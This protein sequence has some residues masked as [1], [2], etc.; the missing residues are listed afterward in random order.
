MNPQS[1]S[2]VTY[3]T[4]SEFMFD[5]LSSRVPFL[6]VGGWGTKWRGFMEKIEFVR[7]YAEKQKEDHIIIFVDGFDTRVIKDPVLAVERFKTEFSSCRALFSYGVV[8]S[9]TF[10]ACRRR[11]FGVKRGPV[12]NSGLYIG[13]AKDLHELMCSI[14]DVGDTDDQRALNTVLASW[15]K[16]RVCIDLQQRIFRNL[17]YE[18]RH[19]ASIVADSEAVFL[20]YNGSITMSRSSCKKILGHVTIFAPELLTI[21]VG[22]A[23]GVVAVLFI[24]RSFRCNCAT[25]AFGIAL[26]IA[27]V[28]VIVDSS[29]VT[30][31]TN[32]VILMVSTMLAFYISYMIKEFC[33]QKLDKSVL[34]RGK[35]LTPESPK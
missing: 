25:A 15:K 30:W 31:Y 24:D 6:V 28:P 8:E 35:K 11:V 26:P 4:H 22:I 18:E 33:K 29:D 32:V 27:I 7:K 21:A 5:E 34:R 9:E 20:G 16:S 10:R 13:Y 12:A 14:K 2:V 17:S 19:N 1:Y 3:A 23:I